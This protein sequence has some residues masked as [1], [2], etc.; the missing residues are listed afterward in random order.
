MNA[1]HITKIKHSQ[2]AANDSGSLYL[3][4][5]TD[6]SYHDGD[7][8]PMAARLPGALSQEQAMLKLDDLRRRAS[9]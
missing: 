6:V 1:L 9:R 2:V 8:H 5:A 3:A 7:G 4:W